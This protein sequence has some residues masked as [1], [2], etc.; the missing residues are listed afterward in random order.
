MRKVALIIMMVLAVV[1]FGAEERWLS[2]T[3][4][5]HY[6]IPDPEPGIFP[7]AN[8]IPYSVIDTFKYDDNMPASAWAWN[9][10]GNGWGV[11]FIAPAPSFTL[12]GALVH[13]YSG[14]PVPG[15]TRAMV[16]VY[17]DDGPGGSP[18]TEIW[19]SDTLTITRGQ[20]N[21][22]SINEPVVGSNYYIFYV[23]V[24]SY[25]ICPGLSI[26]VANNA[27]SHMMWSYLN[28]TFSEDARRGE[29][30]I[31]SVVEWDP[32][33]TDAATLYFAA[34]MP[35]DT[36]PN[37]NLNIRATIRNL[38]TDQLPLGTPVRLKITGPQ[39]YV[40]EDTMTTSA[41]LTRGQT[42][43]MN[44]SPAWRI[45]AVT[46]A[47]R[48]FVWTEAAGEQYPYDDTIIYDLSVA[49]WIE[50]AN[51]NNPRWLT[52]AS[53]ER[54]VKFN[55]AQFGLQYPVGVNRVRTQF[56]L[57]PSYPWPDSTFR[58]KIYA[59]DG[60][61][62]L[63]QSPDI[64]AP[65]GAPGAIKAYDLDSMLIFTSGEFYVAVA[66]VHSSGHPSS[67]ADDTTDSRSYYGTPGGW[68]PWTNGELFISASALGGVGV[69]EGYNPNLR[70]AELRFSNPAQDRLLV[71]WQV[72]AVSRVQLALYDATGRM[73]RELYS[74]EG[75]RSG[76]TEVDLS[77][78]AN[79][80]YLVRL[81]SPAGSATHKLVLNR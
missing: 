60:T 2:P 37:V 6:T 23:Q 78:L 40:Y 80:I 48:I 11:K 71:R 5:H 16:R 76:R 32:P 56:Y 14:W 26:D 47:Y 50:Y 28:G 43:Q 66:P 49:R 21:Y 9:Q 18:G 39:G 74:A 35:P 54:A 52:W 17:A 68:I 7:P 24:D 79:G 61:T 12:K 25:P 4:T 20:W 27:P 41:N 55:P 67:L 81:E 42:A 77:T 51:Y 64:E 34:A 73:V 70:N 15:G 57:H 3:P 33:A 63:Y 8:E 10:G 45:P 38:G 53:P 65:A 59:G 29:W 75:V 13:F 58:F 72:P 31:R 62:L 44:F 19:H 30:L 22:V 36:L 46:G 69:E 1:A